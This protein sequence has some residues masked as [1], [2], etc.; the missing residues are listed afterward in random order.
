MKKLFL[1][2]M[3][4]TSIFLGGC[5][6]PQY[7][8]MAEGAAVG[9]IAG[10]LLGNNSRAVRVG[11]GLGLLVGAVAPTYRQ[12]GYGQPVYAQNG[13]Y[14]GNYPSYGQPAGQPQCPNGAQL[15]Q[16]NGQLVCMNQQPQNYPQPAPYPG[17]PY[18]QPAGQ[19]QCPPG[20][21]LVQMNG[22]L[23][24][25]NQQPQPYGYPQSGSYPAPQQPGVYQVDPRT[26]PRIQI[27]GGGW[28]CQ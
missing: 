12:Q 27:P 6:N 1:L 13:A 2:P 10:A 5:A 20:A 3:I 22:Q 9:G 14:P 16:M 25:M 19:P 8:N 15:V 23:L 11:A 26:C 18:G 24:C 17:Q 21:R 7:Q 28:R 4:A